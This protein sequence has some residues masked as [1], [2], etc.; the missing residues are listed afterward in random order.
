M[1]RI[2]FPG[3]L[4]FIQLPPFR[5]FD[6]NN[7]GSFTEDEAGQLMVDAATVVTQV[8]GKNKDEINY[9]RADGV[10]GPQEM[11]RN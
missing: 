5:L 9:Y 10:D 7:D 3:R 8:A 6:K 11:E 4:I 1:L 2:S